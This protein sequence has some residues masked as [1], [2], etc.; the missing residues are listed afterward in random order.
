MKK[1]GTINSL[2]F[3]I[4][5]LNLA[6]SRQA[7]GHQEV[8]LCPDDYSPPDGSACV[9]L[10]QLLTDDLIKSNTTFKLLPATFTI[11][12]D[13]VIRFENV[14]NITLESAGPNKASISCN[15]NNL[16][17]VVNRVSALSIQKIQF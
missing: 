9:T 16:Q 3:W 1:I 2:I 14:T 15:G 5:A 11:K 13:L 6:S 17:F 8:T 12:Q 7:G 10:D 4:L